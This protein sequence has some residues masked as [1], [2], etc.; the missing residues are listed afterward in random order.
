[1]FARKIECTL[2]HVT[3]PEKGKQDYSYNN[4]WEGG[5]TCSLNDTSHELAKG[6]KGSQTLASGA[7][8]QKKYYITLRFRVAEHPDSGEILNSKVNIQV[9]I[10]Y[11]A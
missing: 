3:L 4:Y 6:Q 5:I 1:M 7:Q 8:K 2:L 11:F 9:K 10:W